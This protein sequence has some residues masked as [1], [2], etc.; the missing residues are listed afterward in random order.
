MKIALIGF[1][2]V[3]QTFAAGFLQNSGVSISAFD[4]AF[5]RN[6]VL[7]QRA[8]S[9][10]VEAAGKAALA[11]AGAD[12]VLSAVTADQCEAVAQDAATYLSPEQIFFDVNSASPNTKRRAAAHI[13]AK[14]GSYVEGAVMA[15]V[16]AP[17]L[18]V[19]ILGGGVRAVELAEKLNPLGMNITPVATEIGEASATKL[20]RSIMIK[21]LE[22]L[23]SDC[24]AAAKKAGVEKAVYASLAETF[25]SIDWPQLAAAMGERVARH[26][27]RRAAEMREAAD[28][29]AEMGFESGL[30]RAV[31][32]RQEQGALANGKG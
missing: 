19:P 9:L 21:G 7:H 22:A 17:K 29:L 23:I 18:A 8:E 5:G 20:C 14:G 15:A 26:G 32:D 1:G 4:I 2:E 30:A 31:A 27:I 13:T 10:G 6:E 12:V 28:M 24:A 25:P 16:L 11:A 3:G